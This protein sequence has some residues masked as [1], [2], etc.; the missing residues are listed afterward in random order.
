MEH[1]TPCIVDLGI[2]LI[3]RRLRIITSWF[4][5]TLLMYNLH[6]SWVMLFLLWAQNVLSPL[7]L[8][9][10]TE[11]ALTFFLKKIEQKF[12]LFEEEIRNTT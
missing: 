4:A 7:F 3:K 6:I 8:T 2:L 5:Y 12:K 1:I 11:R 10:E 9:A